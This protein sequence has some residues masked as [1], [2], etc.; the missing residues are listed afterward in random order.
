[1][2]KKSPGPDGFTGEIYTTFLEE[3]IPILYNLFQKKEGTLLHLFYKA[4]I[5]LIPKPD[6]DSTEIKQNT[7]DTFHLS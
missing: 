5:T 2:K 6:K 3:L 4:S 7:I 1:M